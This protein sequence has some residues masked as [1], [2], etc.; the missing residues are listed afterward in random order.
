MSYCGPRTERDGRGLGAL[1]PTPSNPMPFFFMSLHVMDYEI[2]VKLTKKLS[3]THNIIKVFIWHLFGMT[4]YHSQ[5]CILGASH[6]KDP[7]VTIK[8]SHYSIPS[9]ILHMGIGA[10]SLR[11]QINPK[12]GVLVWIWCL[13]LQYQIRLESISRLAIEGVL[14]RSSF[15]K[16]LDASTAIYLLCLMKSQGLMLFNP[17]FLINIDIQIQNHILYHMHFCFGESLVLK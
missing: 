2:Y 10:L 14:H 17:N 12:S 6:I 3:K 9:L 15:W 8:P 4:C 11:V 16:H 13:G 7:K 5:F 1:L